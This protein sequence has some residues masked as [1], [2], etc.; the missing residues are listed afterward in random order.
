MLENLVGNFN[1][2]TIKKKNRATD[3]EILPSF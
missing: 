3:D 1:F 2:R